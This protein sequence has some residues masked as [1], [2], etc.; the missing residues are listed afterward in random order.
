VREEESVA[1]LFAKVKKRWGRLD[2]L[3]NNA[4]ISQALQP[5]V[6]TPTELWRS[7][8]D[9]NL[10]GTFFC[11]RA[12][13]PLMTRGATVVNIL[14]IASKRNIP[15]FAAYN[16]AKRGALGLTLTLREELIPQGIR[17]VAIMPGATATDIWNQIWAEAPREQ[18]VTPQSVADAVVY[19]VTLPP[20]ANLQELELLPLKGVL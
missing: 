16:A 12:G 11:C 15:N 3:V 18:M 8:I 1:A 19:A 7:V 20:E 5:L 13:V 17:V 9:I 2:I 6:E 14:S 4:G 10:T